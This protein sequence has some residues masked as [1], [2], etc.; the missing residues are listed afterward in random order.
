MLFYSLGKAL[1]PSRLA[2]ARALGFFRPEAALSVIFVSDENDGCFMPDDHGYLAF[3]HYVPSRGGAERIAYRRYCGGVTGASLAS[4]L[5][6]LKG[7]KPVLFGTI[8]HVDPAR[9]PRETEDAVGH[10]QLELVQSSPDGVAI[11]LAETTYSPGLAKL[12]DVV[13]TSLKLRTVFTLTGADGIKKRFIRV[14]V[15]GAPVVSSYDEATFTVQVQ[16]SDAGRAGSLV[17]I[18]GCHAP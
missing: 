17:E 5:R 3:P 7:E 4:S 12:G 10:G 16:A 18:V 9:V 2:E 14:S 15:D 11:D 6:R 13:S 1:T 8:T